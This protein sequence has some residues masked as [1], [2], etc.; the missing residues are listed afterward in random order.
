MK[1]DDYESA[2]R[3]QGVGEGLIQC[4]FE[5]SKFIVDGN[6]QGLKNPRD[7]VFARGPLE[8]SRHGS[9]H[10]RD[11][12]FGGV[13]G[14]GLASRDDFLGDG[15]RKPFFAERFKNPGEFVCVEA[16]Q[17]LVSGSAAGSV[18]PQ[19][20]R[21]SGLEP[22]SARTISQLIGR[23][24]EIEQDSIDLPDLE[25]F[26]DVGEFRITGMMK[27]GVRLLDCRACEAQHH[28]VTV[29]TD[30]Q[31][32]G[33]DS[34]E[35]VLTVSG[36]AEGAIDDRQTTFEVECVEDFPKQNRNVVCRGGWGRFLRRVVVQ[37]GNA[38]KLQGVQIIRGITVVPW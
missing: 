6:S 12:V 24:P 38:G 21:S 34:F 33:T 18:K 11:E 35:D 25:R 19:V 16:G 9:S 27:F 23:K 32:F 31:S 37:G 30:E 28:G 29:Q 14:R 36:S 26:E 4:A 17:K 2:A 22:E 1:R 15:A 13:D 7:G 10:C 3:S 20:E 5:V 8:F